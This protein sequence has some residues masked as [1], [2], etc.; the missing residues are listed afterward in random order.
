V[1]AGGRLNVLS[2]TTL[3]PNRAC[4]HHGLFVKNRLAHM[5][6]YCELTVVAPVNITQDPR[7]VWRTPQRDLQN[8]LVVLH[9]RFAVVPGLFKH[10]DGDLLFRQTMPQIRGILPVDQYD[11]VDAHYAYP[12]GVA[13]Q[14]LA[15]AMHR[16]FVITLRGSDINVLSGFARRRRRIQETLQRAGA[17]VTVSRAL[18]G[19]AA[20]LGADPRKI[21]VIPNGVDTEVFFPRSKHDARLQIGWPVDAHV[22]LSVGRLAAI[23]GFDL[24]I[25]AV[26]AVRDRLKKDVRCYIVGEGELRTALEKDIRQR[27]LAKE[28]VMPGWIPPAQLPLW[29]TA[30]DLFCLP[31]HNE[32]CPNVVLESL[33]CGTPVVATDVGGVSELVREGVS[34]RLVKRRSVEEL[35]TCIASALEARWDQGAILRSEAVR[36]WPEVAATHVALLR[37]VAGCS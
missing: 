15:S 6:R 21:H 3:F 31:S 9:P 27:N 23:K 2:F 4:P 32:G 12:D 10:W 36:S 16:P 34:G 30:A 19:Q 14:R 29:Y 24:L 8:G 35:S 33:A 22:L 28:V 7:A 25:H 37:D 5:A 18:A 1:S 20:A 17:V 13:G 11:V 26:H